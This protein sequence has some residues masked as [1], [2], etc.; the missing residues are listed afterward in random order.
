M[1]KTLKTILILSLAANALWL[2][3]AATGY[4]SLR[5][6]SVASADTRE[7]ASALSP[8]VSKEITAL[9]SA[10]DLTALR[11]QLRKLGLPEDLVRSI[12]EERIAD[13]FNARYQAILKQSMDE[14]RQHPYWRARD[15]GMGR[16]TFRQEKELEDIRRD[17]QRQRRQLFG[18]DALSISQRIMY[19]FLSADKAARLED[20][21][22]DYSALYMQMLQ[23]MSGFRMPGD[24]AKAK[25]LAEEKQRD[26][27]A[28]LTPEEKAENDLRNSD[29]ASGLQYFHLGAFDATEDEYKAIYALQSAFDE[30]YNGDALSLRMHGNADWSDTA[31]AQAQKELDAQIKS[32]LGDERYADYQRAQRSDYQTLQA[33]AQ[34]FD[35]SSET[36]AQTYQVREDTAAAAQQISNDKNLNADEKNQAYSALADQATAQI[37]ASLGDEVGDAYINNALQRLKQLPQGGTVRV[38]EDGG[39]VYVSP[40][41]RAPAK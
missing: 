3:A 26:I 21:N 31:R 29:T 11:D 18:D 27:Q 32:A 25:L 30:K 36:V 37:R 35:L 39:N 28:L 2:L 13:G 34:R 24:E 23:E 22:T 41:P 38:S 12:L 7:P 15:T 8:A 40:P 14:A 10:K 16:M 4:F 19:P 20:L 33:A 6:S 9:L 5:K 17:Q 1:N